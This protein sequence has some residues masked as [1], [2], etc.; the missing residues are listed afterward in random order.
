M[1]SIFTNRKRVLQEKLKTRF[2][3]Y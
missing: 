1:L 2:L 3:N